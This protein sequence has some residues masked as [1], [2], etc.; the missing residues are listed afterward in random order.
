MCS[1]FH[2][3]PDARDLHRQKHGQV[4]YEAAA[5]SLSKGNPQK[6]FTKVAEVAAAALYLCAPAARSVKGRTLNLTGG[7]I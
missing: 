4:S 7:E 2:P 3:H 1:G 5:K 6:L